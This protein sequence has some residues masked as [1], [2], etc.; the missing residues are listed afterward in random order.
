MQHRV[1]AV[2]ASE[3]THIATKSAVVAGIQY[4]AK[5][6]FPSMSL[7]T[8]IIYLVIYCSQV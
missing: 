8:H 1:L 7:H 6:Q 4:S 2:V 5:L 3:L